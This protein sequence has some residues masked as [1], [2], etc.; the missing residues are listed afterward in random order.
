MEI[1]QRKIWKQGQVYIHIFIFCASILL[2]KSYEVIL[3]LLTK[4]QSFN[5][6]YQL[7][8]VVAG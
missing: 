3:N 8:Y 6:F 2:S 7:I 1:D 5:T 4:I